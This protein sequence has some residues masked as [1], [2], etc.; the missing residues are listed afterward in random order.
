MDFEDIV[1]VVE[2]SSTFNRTLLCS[3]VATLVIMV[4]RERVV[5]P[6]ENAPTPSIESLDLL[7]HLGTAVLMLVWKFSLS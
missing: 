4:S 7:R 3:F 2:H 1:F 5:V 6:K